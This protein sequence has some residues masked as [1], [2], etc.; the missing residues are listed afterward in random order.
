MS[1]PCAIII[2]L[3]QPS[4]PKP[5]DATMQTMAEQVAALL[6]G[7]TIRGATLESPGSVA[8]AVEGLER[9]LV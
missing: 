7:W 2:A 8:V 4:D 9:P 5:H 3:G 6:P 1:S